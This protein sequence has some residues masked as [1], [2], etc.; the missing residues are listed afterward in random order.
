LRYWL[1]VATLM[2]AVASGLGQTHTTEPL[3]AKLYS[4]GPRLDRVAR[5]EG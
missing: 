2:P 5:H 4:Q 3:A 1:E